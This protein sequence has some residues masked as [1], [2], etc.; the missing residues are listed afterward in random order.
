MTNVSL[1]LV[2]AASIAAL[3]NVLSRRYK[4]LKKYRWYLTVFIMF[5]GVMVAF[6]KI[7]SADAQIGREEM[8]EIVSK[9]VHEAMVFSELRRSE[10]AIRSYNTVIIDK[11]NFGVEWYNYANN[12][13]E[14]DSLVRAV[15]SYDSAVEYSPLLHEAW[16]NRGLT[17]R[18]LERYE[19][20]LNSYDIS[21][22][23][24]PDC[25]EAWFGR[26]FNLWK[27]DRL[28][29]A[30]TSYDSAISY[31]PNFHQAWHNRGI[32]LWTLGRKKE[33]LAS[34]DS[35]IVYKHDKHE[36]W[37]NR[38]YVLGELDRPKESVD[39]YDS[40]IIYNPSDFI[41]KV[42]WARA[43]FRLHLIVVL[44]I[45]VGLLLIPLGCSL[46]R[47]RRR[48]RRYSS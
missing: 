24:R 27:L 5:A 28:E 21:I 4:R 19:E 44:G 47:Y 34:Y 42:A 38:G 22:N 16:C 48:C 23:C 17:L 14:L 37:F 45:V 46:M 43:Y 9:A 33:S 12:L 32:D 20:S 15:A 36:S 7:F 30:V 1:T 8:A 3:V 10:E 40:A 41:Y 26:A 39:S 18:D 31:R 25:P 2:L 6:F 11:Q 29:E 13:R 35:A